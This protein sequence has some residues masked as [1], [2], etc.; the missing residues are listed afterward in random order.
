[1]NPGQRA[2]PA[3]H[4]LNVGGDILGPRQT[5]NR[6]R[7]RQRILGAVV[8]FPCEQ[9]LTL[10]GALAL[11]DVNRYAADADDPAALV[12][13]RRRRPDAPAHLAVRSND[14]KFGLV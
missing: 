7:Q 4:R 6:L 13:G 2:D 10:L 14:S 5:N 3:L 9:I 1:M 8:D 12:D 11:G